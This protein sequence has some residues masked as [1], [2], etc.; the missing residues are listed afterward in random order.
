MKRVVQ[1]IIVAGVIIKGDKILIIK[2]AKN[3]SHPGLWELPSGKREEFEKTKDAVKREVKEETGLDVEVKIP[4]DVFE[5]RTERQDEIRDAT[6]ISFLTKPLNRTNVK[7]SDEHSDY[8]WITKEE[9]ENYNISPE[10]KEVI[11]KAFYL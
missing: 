3:D 5:F 8:A 7:L 9:I 4:I 11:N 1:K 6:Q 10:T 2:R